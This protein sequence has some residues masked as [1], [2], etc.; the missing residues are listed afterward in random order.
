MRKHL[1]LLSDY[2]TQYLKVRL[3]YKGDL[4][5]AVL[6]SFL[7]TVLALA[8]VLVL[9]SKIP[10]LQGWSFE[11]VLFLYGFSLL[12][13]GLFN[14]VSLN[15]YDFGNLYIMEGKFDRILLRPVNSLFQVIF[16]EFRLES[17]QEVATGI[18]I[19]AY[20]SVKLNLSWRVQD[21]VLA[22]SVVLCGS[23][24][25]LAVFLSLTSVSFWLE[26]R[27]G[28]VPPVFNLLTFGRYPISIY[29]GFVQFLLSWIIPFAFASFY[30]SARFLRRR[31]FDLYFY[32]IP[33][34]A[35]L[36]FT[37]STLVWRQGV[38]NYQ[39]TGS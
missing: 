16:E 19:V 7:A 29:N 31:D 6:T 1:T 18:A 9:F 15:L 23:L 5:I 12:P 33:V 25:Y 38:R 17:L 27:V 4:V 21:L 30:P 39:S 20:C 36:F 14:V 26:D 10:T 13:L 8:F 24:I 34:V 11:E 35:G 28:L 22:S 3:S 37:L 32:L 2:F